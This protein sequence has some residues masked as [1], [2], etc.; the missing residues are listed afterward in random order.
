MSVPVPFQYFGIAGFPADVPGAGRYF[1][2]IFC[3][4]LLSKYHDI[5]IFRFYKLSVD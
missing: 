4:F 5:V 1:F 2:L 3:G